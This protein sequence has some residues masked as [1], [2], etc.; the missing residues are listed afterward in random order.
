MKKYFFRRLIR[1]KTCY[2]SLLVGC[3]LT[4]LNF[5]VDIYPYRADQ[6]VPY[7]I[8]FESYTVSQFASI[9]FV[10]LP[11]L[12][13]LPCANILYRDQI[14]GYLDIVISRNSEKKYFKNLFIVNAI[15]GGLVIALP[16]L[17]NI[18]LC[19]MTL[20]NQQ[21][22]LESV[23]PRIVTFRNSLTLFPRLFYEHSF[24]HM[25]LYVLLG[26]IAG[27]ICAS[28]S[29]GL[30][31][32]VR[33]VVYVYIIPLAIMQVIDLFP[34]KS[35]SLVS[36]SRQ[37]SGASDLKLVLL[38]LIVYTLITIFIYINGIRRKVIL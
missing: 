2:F 13:A 27:A 25:M 15:T 28:L 24:L 8:W 36:I 16:L 30:S 20:P 1:S 32:Y 35:I 7:T 29:L 5:I 33:H 31:W 34:L 21:I 19:F 14:N 18:Y 22:T 3:F 23:D 26:F 9:F 12:A 11:I 37:M 6:N 10:I 4:F 38:T 17:L